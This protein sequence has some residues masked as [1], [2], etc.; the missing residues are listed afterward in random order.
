MMRMRWRLCTTSPLS[1]CSLHVPDADCRVAQWR[2][3]RA[4]RDG[5]N[6]SRAALHPSAALSSFLSPSSST[7]TLPT[8][9]CTLGNC[10]VVHFLFAL[11]LPAPSAAGI[12]IH[13]RESR[14]MYSGMAYAVWH[15]P[16]GQRRK[17]RKIHMD[18]N[19]AP[20]LYDL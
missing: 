19:V 17:S 2:V 12:L 20:I 1:T 14:S 3:S 5:G 6:R 11:P 10:A 15:M 13:A 4:T 8:C 16:N 18:H 9:T 7:F